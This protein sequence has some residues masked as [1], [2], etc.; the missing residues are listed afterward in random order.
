M[1]APQP[2]P[3]D[4][5]SGTE[6]AVV[7]ALEAALLDGALVAGTAIPLYLLVRMRALGIDDHATKAAARLALSEPVHVPRRLRVLR[8]ATA[9][10]KAAE[11]GIRARYLLNAAKR[12]SANLRLLT[13][14]PHALI[15]AIRDE[16]RY[17]RQHFDAIR[18]RRRAA[19]KVDE[20]ALK[21]PWLQWV[22]AG[23]TRVEPE[24][25]ALS[26]SLFTVDNP[27]TVDGRP[28]FP[29]AVHPH[30]R[31]RAL[32][33]GATPLGAARTVTA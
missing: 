26:G 4:G 29:G 30:C 6:D 10:V 20:A 9:Q 21:S 5:L 8:T 28:V 2:T 16:R 32:P 12:I 23:D 22:T 15:T 7:A 19:R 11:P 17:L 27:P 13:N 18:N 14:D 25:R 24:C 33:F 1:T 3:D 31:C